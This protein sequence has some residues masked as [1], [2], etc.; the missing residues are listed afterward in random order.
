MNN[1][2]FFREQILKSEPVFLDEY[3]SEVLHLPAGS[4]ITSKT[5]LDSNVTDTTRII[6]V[7]IT[8]NDINENGHKEKLFLK[9]PVIG[10]EENAFDKWSRHEIDFYKNADRNTGLPLVKCYDAYN[11]DDKNRFLLMLEDISDDYCSA[12]LNYRSE[13]KIWSEAAESLAKFHAFYWNGANSNK[14]KLIHGDDKTIEEKTINY[15]SALEKFLSYA[16]DY[17]DNKILEVYHSAF[18]D[19]ILFERKSIDRRL[20]NN[21]ITVIH[22]DSHIFNFMYPKTSFQKP[23]IIDFQF[24]RMG[25][26]AVDIMN[27]TRVAFPFMNEPERYLELLKH[28]HTALQGY[29]VANYSLDEYLCDFYLSTAIAVFGP[30][31]NYSDFGLGHE[32]WGKGVFDTINNYKMGKKLSGKM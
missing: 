16:S 11:F 31:F 12:T 20:H 22:G 21:N 9:L 10:K 32:Y 23:L 5:I 14:L 1:K 26:A 30:V 7:L 4:K 6:K 29:G 24:W 13:M 3:L 8:W 15:Q 28:Y 25:I 17:Y 19:A 18:E 27:L 2:A